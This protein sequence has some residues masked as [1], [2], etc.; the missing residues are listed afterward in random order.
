MGADNKEYSLEF[1]DGIDDFSLSH[2]SLSQADIDFPPLSTIWDCSYMNTAAHEDP[3]QEDKFIAGWTCGHCHQPM[4]G[5]PDNFL[6]QRMPQRLSIISSRHHHKA[7]VLA[8]VQ[9]H[10]RRKSNINPF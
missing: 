10:I 8:R 6:S 9:F 7:F 1:D 4:Q 5:S 2:H 3:E